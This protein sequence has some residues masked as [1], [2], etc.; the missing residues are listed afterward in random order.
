MKI[1]III[2][3]IIIRFMD[4]RFVQMQLP[5]RFFFT[6][7]VS[8]I[9]LRAFR[10]NSRRCQSDGFELFEKATFSVRQSADN[11]FAMT[12]PFFS[13]DTTSYPNNRFQAAS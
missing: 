4:T 6:T 9:P 2:S 7:H 1:I 11:P 3:V 12:G 8:Q 13:P 5:T 10:L